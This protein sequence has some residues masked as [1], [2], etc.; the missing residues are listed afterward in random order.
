PYRDTLARPSFPTRRSSDLI[1][2]SQRLSLIYRELCRE[3]DRVV[4][5][6]ILQRRIGRDQ[7]LVLRG[8]GVK[9]LECVLFCLVDAPEICVRV[10]RILF[11]TLR[12]EL[13]QFLADDLRVS[14]AV[15]DAHP[16][17]RLVSTPY[18]LVENL[19]TGAFQ[20]VVIACDLNERNT[21]A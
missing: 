20:R 17:D 3:L 14:L 15:L 6:E 19:R 10:L 4:A 13:R 12:I 1:L 7:L 16:Q 11:F 5:P 2:R 8:D 18:S 21:R 9:A